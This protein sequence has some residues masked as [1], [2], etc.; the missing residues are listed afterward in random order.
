MGND[1]NSYKTTEALAI[2][3]VFSS[4]AA[5]AKITKA[6]LAK[7]TKNEANESVSNS[8]AGCLNLAFADKNANDE[9]TYKEVQEVLANCS[10]KDNESQ[11]RTVSSEK[12]KTLVEN[13][14]NKIQQEFISKTPQGR[15]QFIIDKT[16]AYLSESGLT[17]QLEALNRLLGMQDLHH[18]SNDVV[19]GQIKFTNFTDNNVNGGYDAQFRLITTMQYPSAYS[20][21]IDGQSKDVGITTW[22]SDEDTSED[23]FGI[24]LN[25]KYITSSNVKWYEAVETLVHELVHAS[26]Y[27]YFTGDKVYY[28]A[29]GVYVSQWS[30]YAIDKMFDCGINTE[31]PATTN[32]S[33]D[34]IKS[35]ESEYINTT[36]IN[37]LGMPILQFIQFMTGEYMAYSYSADF[38]DSIGAD[39]WTNDALAK[40]G[41][42]TSTAELAESYETEAIKTHVKNNYDNEDPDHPTWIEIPPKYGSAYPT[43]DGEYNNWRNWTA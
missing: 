21:Y 2:S 22:A 7:A 35:H 40:T 43:N 17:T 32:N 19:S 5:G 34:Y 12:L 25:K 39:F 16:R 11:E 28:D 41:V 36:N 13:C 31:L 20:T 30:G 38:L 10:V 26:A 15:A 14:S 37:T 4:Q 42:K 27:K 6:Q 29:G 24:T 8:I 33:K 1:T 18:T 23:D 3:L 9:I